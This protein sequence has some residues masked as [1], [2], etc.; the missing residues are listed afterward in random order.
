[1]THRPTPNRPWVVIATKA[2]GNSCIIS[3]MTWAASSWGIPWARRNGRHRQ[4]SALLVAEGRLPR[5][6]GIRSTVSLRQ[7]ESVYPKPLKCPRHGVKRAQRLRPVERHD[8]AFQLCLP[9]GSDIFSAPNNEQRSIDGVKNLVRQ[10]Q[11]ILYYPNTT[12]APQAGNG[13]FLAGVKSKISCSNA[14][15]PPGSARLAG[16]PSTNISAP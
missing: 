16:G 8:Y 11:A 2:S 13:L 6:H 7:G 14:E 9:R 15:L 12:C 1:M 5:G 4:P 3:T 10:F